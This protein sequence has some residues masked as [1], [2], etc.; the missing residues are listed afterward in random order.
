MCALLL[1]PGDNPI[2]VSKYIISYRGRA[3]RRL[4]SL[5]KVMCGNGVKEI[6]VNGRRKG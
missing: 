5:K 1:P 2:A 3:R 6:S 4:A